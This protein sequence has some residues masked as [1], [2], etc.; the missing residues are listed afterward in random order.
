MRKFLALTGACV[1]LAGCG[2][3]SRHD[4]RSD[5]AVS[6]ILVDDDSAVGRAVK[7]GVTLRFVA[8]HVPNDAVAIVDGEPITKA[9]YD[10]WFEITA[11]SASATGREP[12]IPDPPAYARCVA[13]LK[14]RAG[15]VRGRKAPSESQLRA[16]CRRRDRTLRQQTMALLIQS[17]WFEKEAEALGIDVSD[18]KVEKVLRDTKRQSFPRKGDYERFLRATGMTQDDVLFRLRV[19]E[20]G[21]AITRH[22]QRGAG[23]DKRKRLE[24]FGRE[25]QKRW[26]EQTECRAGFVIRSFCGNERTPARGRAGA[27]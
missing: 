26:T 11:R 13:A 18:A 4:D 3:S 22:V 1:L 9:D 2:G 8:Q 14:E 6:P 20:L 17:I 10:H 23:K 21:T 15:R 12:V 25:F 27:A 19:N 5:R 16:Q 24:A 7:N